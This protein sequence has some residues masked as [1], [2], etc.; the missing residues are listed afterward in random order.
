MNLRYERR[1]AND[2]KEKKGQL[3]K[4]FSLQTFIVQFCE[5]F[6]WIED[7]FSRP[8]DGDFEILNSMFARIIEVF[9]YYDFT[10]DKSS[11]QKF[12]WSFVEL[13]KLGKYQRAGGKVIKKCKN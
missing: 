11:S 13:F 10:M 2:E 1:H 3:F 12:I 8:S 5:F 7:F 9:F 6:L 4:I